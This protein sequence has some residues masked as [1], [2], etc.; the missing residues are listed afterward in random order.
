M[1]FKK[2]WTACR[3]LDFP[4]VFYCPEIALSMSIDWLNSCINKSHLLIGQLW[5]VLICNV[6]GFMQISICIWLA[7]WECFLKCLTYLTQL[8]FRLLKNVKLMSSVFR[9]NLKKRSRLLNL[10]K[11]WRSTSARVLSS[12]RPVI[13]HRLKTNSSNSDK[14]CFGV[15]NNYLF[16]FW[17]A[18]YSRWYL[19]INFTRTSAFYQFLVN[20][21]NNLQFVALWWQE[22]GRAAQTADCWKR[23]KNKEGLLGSKNQNLSA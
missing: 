7:F 5:Q 2:T 4:S 17:W 19:K 12:I 20:L 18:Y 21:L 1:N 6:I 16:W 10:V 8:I 11:P 22:Q 13:F 9:S 15:L 3:R 23:G 14:R